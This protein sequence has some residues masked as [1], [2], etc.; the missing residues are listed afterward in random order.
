MTHIAEGAHTPVSTA[1]LRV[2]VGRLQVPGA[3]G[4]DAAALLLDGP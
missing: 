2:A 4:A 1:P 3:P